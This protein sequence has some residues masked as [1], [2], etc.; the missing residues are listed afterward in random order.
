MSHKET[1]TFDL[2]SIYISSCI[3]APFVGYLSDRLPARWIA[4]IAALTGTLGIVFTGL[5]PSLTAAILCYGLVAGEEE[6]ESLSHSFS[7]TVILNLSFSLYIYL[8]LSP[9]CLPPPRSISFLLCP[10]CYTIL[11]FSLC[12]VSISNSTM[13]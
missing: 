13:K 3:P 6:E 2:H 11:W 10:S 7:L 8:P 12:P 1:Y 4:M 5:A 9:I